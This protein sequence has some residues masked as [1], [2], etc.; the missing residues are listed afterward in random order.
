MALNFPLNPIS[1]QTY[2]NNGRD[3]VFNGAAWDSVN[4]QSLGPQGV[5]GTQGSTGIQGVQG[6]TGVQGYTGLQGSTGPQGFTGNQGQT[7]PQGSTGLQGNIGPQG[8]T[9]NQGVTGPQGFTGLQGNIGPQGTAGRSNQFY[10]YLAN[11]SSTVDSY[12]EDSYTEDG[13]TAP[14]AYIIW[15][16]PTQISATALSVSHIDELGDDIDIFLE[17]ISAGDK[18]IIQDRNNSDSYQQWLV[19]GP[20]NTTPTTYVDIPVSLVTATGLG[21]TNFPNGREVILVV[22]SIGA[23]GPQGPQGFTGNQ[24]VTGPQGLTGIQGSTGPQGNTGVQG[25]TGPQGYT[26]IQGSTGPQGFTGVQGNTGPQ[27]FT[28][29]QGET[30]PQGFTG[31]QG[32]TGP[33]GHTGVQGFTG[34]QGSTGPQGFTGNQGFTGPQGYTGI[35]GSTGFQGETGPQGF[36]GLQGETGP[37]GFTGNQ[38]ETGPTGNQG[39]TGPQ[40]STGLQ[41]FTGPQGPASNPNVSLTFSSVITIGV[42]HNS[43][44]YP[45]VQ[46]FDESGNVFIP[47]YL[48]HTSTS[49]FQITFA[50]TSSGV[51]IYG[52]GAGPQ[53]PIGEPGV[54]GDPGGPVGPTGLQGNTGPQGPAV[55]PNISITFSSSDLITITHNSGSYPFVQIFDDTG[56]VFV[57]DSIVHSTTAS[58]ELVFGTYT[59]GTIIYGGGAGPQG[60]VGDPGPPGGPPGPT[61]IQGTTGPQGYQGFTGPQ[62]FTGNQGVSGPQGNTG[63]QGNTGPQGFTG[64]QG[65]SGPQGN[66]GSQGNT[67]PQGSTGP[68]GIT[69]GSFGL[70]IDGGSSVITTGS[71]GYVSMPYGGSITGWDILGNDSGSISIDL[72]K[73]TYTGFPTTTSVTSTNYISLSSQQKNTS[74]T[75]SGWLSVTF[76]STEIYEFYVNSASIV[77]RVNVVIRTNK[78]S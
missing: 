60:P 68:S 28:G 63:A 24:G 70:T 37:Q 53:G 43:G 30:G 45:F 78:T 34:L 31:N 42:T 29:N 13:Y 58:F 14:T 23:T 39:F 72:K 26:G 10:N 22:S 46:T 36:T 47:K 17:L 61:G 4:T 59:S 71:K 40:G 18:I 12:V 25:F 49:S 55:Q 19:N 62:G 21:Y 41:G 16:N 67:G 44:Q 32:T 15:N 27:G 50:T 74:S 52:G 57:P 77:T 69:I 11:T 38:G 1:G 76:S 7:G 54:P 65:V 75:L 3:W 9:G 20:L 51:I 6:F 66:T 2:S 5:Q 35:Q 73:S 8:F 64:N 48:I 56:N 33:Q